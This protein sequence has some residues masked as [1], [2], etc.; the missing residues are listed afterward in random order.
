MQEY[1]IRTVVVSNIEAEAAGVTV[2]DQY[3]WD[4]VQC[5]CS[6]HIYLTCWC[7]LG[8]GQYEWDLHGCAR[9]SRGRLAC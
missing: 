7:V 8:G 4:E 5:N 3:E 2:G 1:G 6:V 9:L